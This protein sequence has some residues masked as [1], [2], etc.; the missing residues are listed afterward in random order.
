[1]REALLFWLTAEVVGLAALPVAA[2]LF[3]RLP[4]RGLVLARPLG[5]LL[6][7]YPAWLLASLHA[8]PY[9][10]ASAP[11]GLALLVV[12]GFLLAR[13]AVAALQD[14]G[15]RR[16]WLAGEV[17]FTAA[18]AGWAL[19]RSFAPDVWNT[20]KPMNMAFV[21][22]INRSDF[23]PPHDPWLAGETLNYYY[24]GHYLVGLLVKTTGAVP[25]VGFNVAVALFYAL[26]ASSVFGVAATLS[27]ALRRGAGPGKAIVDG[28]FAAAVALALGNLAGATGLLGD[29]RPLRAYDWWAPSRV[30]DG[31]ANE[32]PFFSFLLGDLHAHTMV[33]PFSL[34]AL[35]L[36]LQ[37]ALAGPRLPER[38]AL[39]AV[40][41][42]LVLS[43][44]VLGS[45]YA[46]NPFDLPTGAM[47]VAG[48]LV[49]H[50]ASD[51]SGRPLAS[52]IWLAGLLAAAAVLFAP[53]VFDFSPTA[54][55]IGLVRE[56][57]PFTRFGADTL[58]IYALPLLVVAAALVRRLAVP[59]RYLAW[60]GT[61]LLV[62]LVLLAPSRLAGLF[63]VLSIGAVALYSA[64]DTRLRVADRFF[65]L[66]VGAAL[67]L[68]A[69][70]EFVYVRDAFDGTV[71][72][73]F[74]TVFKTGYQAWFLLAIVVGVGL[75]LATGWL[76]RRSLLVWRAGIVVV[77][78]L[79]AVYP[80]AGSYALT[81][82]FSGR[83]TLDGLAWLKASA[84]GDAEVIAWL[85]RSVE[86]SPVVLEAVGPDFSPLGHGRISTFTGLPTVVGWLGH[87]VQWGHDPEGRAADVDVIYATRDLARARRLLARYAVR[88][89]VVGSLEREQYR[90][91]ALAKFDRLGKQVFRSGASRVYAIP[92]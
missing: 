2:F 8:V 82:G 25:E 53:F 77:A 16:L 11:L 18:F 85:R 83:P 41:G 39:P 49:L 86:S 69:I 80:V 70:G 44:L 6:L 40:V 78:A 71:S 64:L 50:L 42:E 4:G 67:A 91:A 62:T 43:A 34:V 76:R 72:Y 21:N 26:V 12:L 81:G 89:V 48:G 54:E 68:V 13:R 45:L 47:L 46:L 3:S 31:T 74:N 59:R 51:G 65:W 88:Y 9:G 23:F 33:T 55:G 61:A 58:L 75:R 28:G 35:A 22:A 60:S 5:L 52:L 1:M 17:L 29:V 15:S 20:E 38:D 14:P 32:F 30:I 84:P 92:G 57:A 79:L 73:R 87:E 63:L 90:A 37:L 19:L 66:L 7:G 10:R 24:F 56:H 36:A 27:L